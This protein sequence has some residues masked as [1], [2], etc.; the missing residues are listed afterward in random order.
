MYYK[1]RCTI[2][3]SSHDSLI[4]CLQLIVGDDMASPDARSEGF[5]AEA[6]AGFIEPNEY[7]VLRQQNIA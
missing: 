7:E 6:P 2:L 4:T 3:H 5:A 1:Q